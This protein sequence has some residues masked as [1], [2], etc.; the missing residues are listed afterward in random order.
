MKQASEMDALVR[1]LE[2]SGADRTRWPAQERLR[3]APLIAH[4]EVAR[5]LVAE[6]AA[7]DLVLDQAPVLERARHAPLIDRIVAAAEAEGMKVASNVVPFGGAGRK[8]QPGADKAPLVRRGTWQAAALLAASLV[9]GVFAGSS[10]MIGSAVSPFG[11][12][13]ATADA[14]ADVSELILA[15]SPS[16]PLEDA[17]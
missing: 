2:I 14:D 1:R 15:G 16:S 12:S 3:F 10:G 7:L 13:F 8:S 11:G 5:Q 4:D 6:A 9:V 17:L